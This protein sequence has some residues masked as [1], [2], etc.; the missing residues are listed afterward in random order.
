M[1]LLKKF[2]KQFK[3]TID[4][5]NFAA[6]HGHGIVDSHFSHIKTA[7]VQ[8]LNQ[9]QA[10]APCEIPALTLNDVANTIGNLANTTVIPMLTINRAATRKIEVSPISG[11]RSLYSFRFTPT[12]GWK[13]E[14]STEIATG[15]KVYEIQFSKKR[16][17]PMKEQS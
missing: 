17:K 3:L 8:V 13:F 1:F 5:H 11:I 9:Q 7:I 12:Q 6:Y 4:V 2:A 16:K 10:I 14:A 15:Y